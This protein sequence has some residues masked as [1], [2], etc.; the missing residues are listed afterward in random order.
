MK[1][2]TEWNYFSPWQYLFSSSFVKIKWR[3]TFPVTYENIL[4]IYR[5]KKKK[6]SILKQT[7]VY[8]QI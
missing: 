8:V 4:W 3:E 2:K 7:L 1:S 6:F 5:N